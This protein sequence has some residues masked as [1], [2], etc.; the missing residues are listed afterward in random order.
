MGEQ[1]VALAPASS[2]GRRGQGEQTAQR[3]AHEAGADLRGVAQ[4]RLGQSLVLLYGGWLA[5]HSDAT[6][7]SATID[8]IIAQKIGRDADDVP[9]RG[10]LLPVPGVEPHYQ[11]IVDRVGQMDT[12]EVQVEM[13]EGL[14]SDRV[15]PEFDQPFYVGFEI[16]GYELGLL[17][18]EGR[19]GP[20]GGV[21]YWR[22]DEIGAALARFA[23][24]GAPTIEEAKDVGEGIKVATVAD[25]FGNGYC[26]L[27]F[28]GRG[29]EEM[30]SGDTDL[31]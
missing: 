21:A 30:A 2:L 9:V 11:L 27:E 5:F 22:V 15:G 13:T 24:A 25:P 7:G 26:L 23:A 12:L 3:L 4:Q 6:V 14:F 31:A 16:G 17:P 8:Q 10:D 1:K 28:R 19:P 29:Y 20:E 18:D